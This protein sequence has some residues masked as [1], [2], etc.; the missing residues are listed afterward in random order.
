[1]GAKTLR[2]T[3]R[4]LDMATLRA[5]VRKE[6]AMPPSAHFKLMLEGRELDSAE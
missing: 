1:M 2:V 4:G 6:L 3:R 5:H